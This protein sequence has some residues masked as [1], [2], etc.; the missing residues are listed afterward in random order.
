MLRIVTLGLSLQ[1]QDCDK[2][3]LNHN[4]NHVRIIVSKYTCVKVKASEI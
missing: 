2:H 1:M 3:N 4:H